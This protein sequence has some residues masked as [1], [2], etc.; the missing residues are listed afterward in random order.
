[1]S[2]RA[3]VR[4]RA[5]D[6]EECLRSPA[7]PGAASAALYARRGHSGTAFGRGQD[8]IVDRRDVL[9]RDLKK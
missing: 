8:R 3:R 9:E 4:L 5:L 6:V 7:G 1:M 2:V